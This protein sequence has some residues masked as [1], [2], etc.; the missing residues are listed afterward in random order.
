MASGFLKAHIELRK[1]R[2]QSSSH[3]ETSRVSAQVWHQRPPHGIHVLAKRAAFAAVC[4][5][6]FIESD[7]TKIASSW[8]LTSLGDP[9]ACNHAAGEGQGCPQSLCPDALPTSPGLAPYLFHTQISSCCAEPRPLSTSAQTDPPQPRVP[10]ARSQTQTSG[11]ESRQ[12]TVSLTRSAQWPGAREKCRVQLL[13][14]NETRWPRR[15][16]M[17]VLDVL[18]ANH[19]QL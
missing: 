6:I 10:P 9:P 2:P 1:G 4:L 15:P 8:L 17:D 18:V 3:A 11:M 12:V 7:L 14:G 13:L 16:V 19:R 5:Q